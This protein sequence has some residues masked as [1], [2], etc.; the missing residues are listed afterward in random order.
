MSGMASW[1][2]GLSD[3]DLEEEDEQLGKPRIFTAR[4]DG[5]CSG[6]GDR[7]FAGE[8]VFYEDDELYAA[9]CCGD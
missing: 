4:Y 3:A 2:D 5:R 6:C 7:F 1:G 8:E 9:E